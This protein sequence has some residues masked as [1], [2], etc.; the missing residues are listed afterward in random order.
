MLKDQTEGLVSV[1]ARHGDKAMI[2]LQPRTEA[3]LDVAAMEKRAT[4]AEDEI[5]AA[6]NTRGLEQTD[7][8][9]DKQRVLVTDDLRIIE[10][11]AIGVFPEGDSHGLGA[12]RADGRKFLICDGIQ[13]IE[14]VLHGQVAKDAIRRIDGQGRR[15]RRA[16]VPPLGIVLTGGGIETQHREQSV[17][18][19]QLHTRFRDGDFLVPHA[20]AQQ[21]TVWRLARFG[22]KRFAQRRERRCR[23]PVAGTDDGVERYR[24][25]DD[26][27]SHGHGQKRRSARSGNK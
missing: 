17:F 6:R 10:Q 2:A 23:A 9:V 12:L 8:G 27:L 22:G 25:S 24:R 18:A 19:D 16:P 14:T 15:T 1:G 13:I 5:D 4:G 20:F 3:R 11:R 26:T 7:T 21:D